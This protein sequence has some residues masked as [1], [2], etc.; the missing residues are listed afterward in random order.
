MLKIAYRG[1]FWHGTNKTNLRKILKEGLIPDRPEKVYDTGW[2]GPGFKS[3]DTYGGIY[4]TDK[5]S[6]A[7][8]YAGKAQ[9]GIGQGKIIVGV[10]LETRTAK[11]YK[12]DVAKVY[13]DEDN[14]FHL[15]EKILRVRHSGEISRVVQDLNY[16]EDLGDWVFRVKKADLSYYV[17]EI[18][19]Y[20]KEDYPRF[21]E[22]YSKQGHLFDTVLDKLIKTYFFHLKESDLA[23]AYPKEIS[24]PYQSKDKKWNL[25]Q[26]LRYQDKLN[27]KG[28]T[29]PELKN[30]WATLNRYMTAFSEFVPEMVD[31]PKNEKLSSEFR[32]MFPITYSGKNKIV[33]VI[34]QTEEYPD[35]EG[36]SWGLHVDTF[37]VLYSRG[38]I[39]ALIKIIS[40]SK[41]F[42]NFQIKDKNGNI[43]HKENGYEKMKTSASYYIWKE[44]TVVDDFNGYRI[45]VDRPGHATHVT[46]WDKEGKKVGTL[47]TVGRYERTGYL[48]VDYVSVDAYH[49]G[50]GLA[51]KMYLTLLAN[52]SPDYK[53]ISSYLPDVRNKKQVPAIWKSL[54]AKVLKDNEDLLV[55]DKDKIKTSSYSSS[56]YFKTAAKKEVTDFPSKGEN[57]SITLL[58]SEYPQADY[59]YCKKIKENYPE[60]WARGGNEYGNTAFQYW[61]KYRKGDRSLGVL[62]W[63]KKREAWFARHWGN[64]K[65]PGIIAWLKWGGYGHLGESKVKQMLREE[66]R[67]IDAKK[68]T[69]AGLTDLNGFDKKVGRIISDALY[70]TYNSEPDIIK[71][72]SYF[73]Y[74]LQRNLEEK[75][76]RLHNGGFP[77]SSFGDLKEVFRDRSGNIKNFDIVTT[78]SRLPLVFTFDSGGNTLGA[79][80]HRVKNNI[81]LA[82]FNIIDYSMLFGELDK[83]KLYHA[84]SSTFGHELHHAIDWFYSRYKKDDF[85]SD[86]SSSSSSNLGDDPTYYNS[87]TEL[88]SWAYTIA[89]DILEDVSSKSVRQIRDLLEMTS[90]DLFGKY[91]I[92]KRPKIKKIWDLVYPENR[93]N[94]I[95]RVLTVIRREALSMYKDIQEQSLREYPLDPDEKPF[96]QRGKHRDNWV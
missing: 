6:F 27:S 24:P 15:L 18:V 84:V 12:E 58:N 57:L 26:N 50:N 49:R 47:A 64:K 31:K 90:E 60:L 93:R 52:L 75:G 44:K 62:N 83:S 19:N 41:R 72:K 96:Y 70:E 77:L 71:N 66:M 88:K 10:T 2:S 61:T 13:W 1:L 65:I 76:Y 86:R 3:N 42:I 51:K 67:K 17:T 22:R 29:P 95:T 68:K 59:A 78:L 82:V 48:N 9:K 28:Y 87:D 54:G 21:S 11:P 5:F 79:F 92:F 94:F 4:L 43:L 7:A 16:V 53:G 89:Q 80:N 46:A 36:D 8:S 37:T 55:V 91:G 56:E 33:Y 30:T 40:Y 85:G 63:V 39:E 14:I 20:L 74:T 45:V 73:M 32:I 69:A 25:L 23:Q 81:M 38:S 35:R 34:E